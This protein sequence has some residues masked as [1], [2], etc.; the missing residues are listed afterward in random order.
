MEEEEEKP[1]LRDSDVNDAYAQCYSSDTLSSKQCWTSDVFAKQCQI[2]VAVFSV[3]FDTKQGPFYSGE[4][5][6]VDQLFFLLIVF[7]DNLL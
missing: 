7:P 4:L 5:V 2:I 3:I 1:L 6:S